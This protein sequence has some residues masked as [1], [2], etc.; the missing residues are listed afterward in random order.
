MSLAE[1]RLSFPSLVYLGGSRTFWLSKLLTVGRSEI[2]VG[3][4]FFNP[5]PKVVSSFVGFQNCSNLGELFFLV[6][7]GDEIF[8]L[9]STFDCLKQPNLGSFLTYRPFLVHELRLKNHWST[10]WL[11]YFQEH[12]PP[13][14][15]L[16]V[17]GQFWSGV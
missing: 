9:I 12:T 2:F 16:S 17:F 3:E 1:V 8:L 10:A 6:C 14:S 5:W 13:H 11:L 4:P 7:R 15:P